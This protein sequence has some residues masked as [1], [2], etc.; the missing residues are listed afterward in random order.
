MGTGIIRGA[1]KSVCRAVKSIFSDSSDEVSR[2]VGSSDSFDVER[3]NAQ[4]IERMNE[5]L[6]GYSKKYSKIATELE[7]NVFDEINETVDQIIESLSDVNNI[8]IDGKKIK[9][10]FKS[11]KREMSSFERQNSGKFMGAIYQALSIDN[12]ECLNILKLDSGIDKEKQMKQFL[13]EILRKELGKLNKLIEKTL[14]ENLDILSEALR[15][16]ITELEES[17]SE[18]ISSFKALEE[19]RDLD[20]KEKDKLLE[21][22]LKEKIAYKGVLN[23]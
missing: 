7:R 10:N 13:V 4:R 19:T 5:E 18:D 6:L 3:A 14:N 21:N 9:I 20:I 22:K 2:S 11:L 16:K 17:I 23:G 1:V 12:K 8:R 15:D